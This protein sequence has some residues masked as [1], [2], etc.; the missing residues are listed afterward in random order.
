MKNCRKNCP[1]GNNQTADVKLD[2]FLV[3]L[4]VCW[5]CMQRASLCLKICRIR[6]FDILTVN[7]FAFYNVGG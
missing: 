7:V 4:S 1:N 5:N 6:N 3:C 2:C